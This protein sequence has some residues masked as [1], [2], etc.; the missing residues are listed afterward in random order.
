VTVKVPAE[1]QLWFNNTLT[2]TRGTV[3]QFDSPPLASGNYVYNVKARW[4]ENGHEVTQTQ[5]VEVTG[6][7]QVDVSFPVLPATEKPPTVGG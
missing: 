2:T 3:R 5:R 6:G 1:A 7:A 4:T